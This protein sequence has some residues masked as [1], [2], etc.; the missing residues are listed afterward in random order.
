VYL[1]T[2][3]LKCRLELPGVVSLKEKR[4]ILKSLTVRLRNSFN[5]SIAEV[6]DNDVLR[7]AT[8]AAAVVANSSSFAHQVIARVADRIES[9]SDLI[10]VDYGT[11]S[12]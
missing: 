1:V 3:T 8:L 4:R 7:T 5:I 9:E 6:G 11:E 10:L 12:Y 2:V